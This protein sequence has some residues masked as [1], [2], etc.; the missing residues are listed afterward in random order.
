MLSSLSSL[1]GKRDNGSSHAAEPSLTTILSTASSRTELTILLA[2]ITDSMR[3]HLE[4][5]FTATLA[6]SDLYDTPEISP[7]PSSSG[8]PQQSSPPQAKKQD[9]QDDRAWVDFVKS[10]IAAQ[11][12][13][14]QELEK[15]KKE[16]STEKMQIM[17][18]RCL[19]K[20][21][22]WRE[23]VL[24]RIGEVVNNR[25]EPA[26]ERNTGSGQQEVK[27]DKQAE[28]KVAEVQDA[29]LVKQALEREYPPVDTPLVDLDRAKKALILHSM[30]LLLLSLEQYTAWSRVLLLYLTS[31][32]SLPVKLLEEDEA[33]IAS[34]L[35]HAVDMSGETSTK[36]AA[37]ENAFSRKWKVGLATVAGAAVI[38]ITGGLAAPLLAAGVGSVMGGL[39]L[40]A[41]ATAGY[42]GTLA[43]SSVL[44]GGLF[45]AY[46]GKMTGE[47]MDQ[48]AKEVEDFAF[49]PVRSPS[50]KDKDA[51]A[52]RR[53]RVTVGV[54][55]WLGSADDV[56]KP[57]KVLGP[58][59][60]ETFALRF[61]LKALLALGNALTTLLK[62]AAWGYAKSE[63]IKRTVFA[64]LTA[65][66][67]PIGLLKVSRLVDN[68][69]SVAKA[70]ADKAGEVL[71]DAI[72]NKAQGERPISLIGY[73]LG[74]R[75]IYV[76]LKKMAERGAFG[77]VEDVI[78]LGAP[79]PSDALDWR[80][81]RAVAAG[82]VVNVYSSQ[83]Y[84]L[85]FLYRSSSVQLGVAGLQAID[86]NVKGVESLDFSSEIQGHTSWRF[87]VGK[88][89]QRLGVGDLVL[90]EV[91][92]QG[93][94]GKEVKKDEDESRALAEKKE[95]G[96]EPSDE[97]VKKLEEKVEQR[98]KE[99]GVTVDT[100]KMKVDDANAEKLGAGA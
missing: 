34:G 86:P 6:A 91:E 11:E 4:A 23:R 99:A 35:L 5:N 25:D 10:D 89:L 14:R 70:R 28:E 36:K 74:A 66:L 43:G 95:N 81:V 42:L 59:S 49:I 88:A 33:K 55:G 41:T 15:R 31:S 87:S 1:T 47:M 29:P 79:A 32:L 24:M 8:Q 78:L 2:N 46:G 67:W 94:E 71:A 22:D 45:G 93:R 30:L 16:L 64:S 53:L 97:H 17:K 38:G 92:R 82:R 21:D 61:E 68:P 60:A 63:I 56:D 18:R 75:T 85:G 90:E 62:S 96:K 58:T 80:I 20:F 100:G 73:S 77:L 26:A 37:D 52:Q 3:K 44:V 50:P 7:P 76:C 48:Y 72:I 40:G 54:S 83:D 27:T 9:K 19:H 65:A 69:F 13:V 12:K 51:N 98:N 57:W 84:I 39:G